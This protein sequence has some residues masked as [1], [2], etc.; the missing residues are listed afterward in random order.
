[1][2]SGRP[3]VKFTYAEYLTL[4]VGSRHQLIEGDL[5]MS[6]APTRRHQ[7]VVKRLFRVLDGFVNSRRMGEVYFSPIDVILSDEDVTQP[8]IVYISKGRAGLLAP[9]GVRGGPDLCVEVLSDR[10]EALDRGAK[11]VLYARH[12]VTEYWI[13]DPE[14]NTLD[15]Y[16]LQEDAK[17]SARRLLPADMLTTELLP[18]FSAP[19][20]DVFAL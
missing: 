15:V 3:P 16:R 12:G 13:V 10:T 9:E 14:G 1:M 2:P 18:G 11:R 20:A 6:P 19:L 5:V 8:D 17:A 7:T 4:P